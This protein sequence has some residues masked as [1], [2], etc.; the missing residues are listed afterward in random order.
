MV[1]SCQDIFSDSTVCSRSPWRWKDIFAESWLCKLICR[2]LVSF[3]K[4]WLWIKMYILFLVFICIVCCDLM[5]NF[6]NGVE[7][8]LHCRVGGTSGQNFPPDNLGFV[9]N[10]YESRFQ[11]L[12]WGKFNIG[13]CRFVGCGF[14]YSVKKTEPFSTKPPI[15]WSQTLN[16]Q[17][18][19]ELL[20]VYHI[21]WNHL[22]AVSK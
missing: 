6:C 10:F 18:L 12:L 21:I 22:R 17:P 8:R 9:Q 3:F 19:R 14:L 20:L 15:T 5:N 7:D 4:C 11:H 2:V 1:I 13:V 16:L